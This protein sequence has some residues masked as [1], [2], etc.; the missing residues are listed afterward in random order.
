[1][2]AVRLLPCKAPKG[3]IWRDGAGRA[4]RGWERL[5]SRPR[6]GVSHEDSNRG[7]AVSTLPHRW[8][9]LSCAACE[10]HLSTAAYAMCRPCCVLSLAGILQ[11][12]TQD[13]AV[14]DGQ[15]GGSIAMCP[16]YCLGLPAEPSHM[17]M[18]T[19]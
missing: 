2:W 12:G 14:T 10:L 7:P 9:S 17:V 5:G 15:P 13:L 8:D 16:L 1:M 18:M 6:H 4:A 3:H 11:A 19:M